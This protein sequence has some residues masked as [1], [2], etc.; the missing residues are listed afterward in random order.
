MNPTPPPAADPVA[1][2]PAGPAPAGQ[3]AVEFVRGQRQTAAYVF[4]G[5]SVLFLGATI[6]L[7]S[8]AFRTPTALDTP[9]A[10]TKSLDPEAL[11]ETPKPEIA[12]P[13]RPSYMFGGIGTLLGFLVTASVGGMLLAGVPKP[14]VAAQRTEARVVLL[15][16]GGLIGFALIVFGGGYFYLWSDSLAKWL[17]KGERKEMIWVVVPLLMIV[18]GAGLVIAATQPARAE[19][20]NNPGLR[21]LVYGANLG[22]TALLLFVALLA[23]NVVIALKVPNKLDTTETGFY[24]LSDTTKAFLGKLGEPVNLYVILP[25]SGDR[26]VNDIRQFALVA[27]DASDGKLTTRFVSPVT[28][29]VEIQRLQEKYPR[30]DRNALGVLLTA[31]ADEKRNVFVPIDDLFDMDQKTG[32]PKGFAGE[33]KVMR[34]LRFLADNEQKPVVYFTQANGELGVGTGADTGVGQAGSQVKAF[35]EKAYLDVRPLV[36]PAQK[37]AV[38]DDAAVVVV[39]EPQSPLG[40]GAVEAVRKYMTDARPDGRKGKL[41][42][43]AGAVAGADNRGVGKTGLEGLLAEFNVRLGDKFVYSLPI[44]Q[45]P[46][47]KVALVGFAKASEQNPIYQTMSAQ[48]RAFGFQ[49]PRE[50]QPLTTNPVFQATALLQTLR[51]RP[52]WLEEDRITDPEQ[53]SQDL[54]NEAIRVRRGFTAEPRPVGVVV[55]EAGG[56]PRGPGGAGRAVVIGNAYVV[57]DDYARRVRG[58]PASFD[59]LA[60]S[61]DWLRDRPALAT[62]VESKVYKEYT[63]PE[64]T[65]VDTTRLLYFPLG[66]GLLGVAGLGAGVWVIRR[67]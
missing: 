18:A 51:G 21:R 35:L 44:E 66:L 19:E 20:R 27:Q 61:I 15:A 24:S 47:Y 50:V 62:T 49:L 7:A 4:L 53:I 6:W 17:D 36:F 34:E 30:I 2:P 64:P 31:G 54:Q 33:S 57:S 8:R 58:T 65:A 12:D 1:P 59:L 56:T 13:K 16:A 23:A 5:L 60:V 29:K 25:D 45:A 40:A 28:N 43:L 48:V 63:F 52:T 37:P 26:E 14:T 10:A 22:L 11:P 46:D 55:S 32:R 39:A 41:I 67:K 9:P 3:G 38:P 42:V